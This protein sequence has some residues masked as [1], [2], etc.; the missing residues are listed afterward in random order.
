[1]EEII[2]I[3]AA[4]PDGSVFKAVV[5]ALRGYLL[6]DDNRRWVKKVSH[7]FWQG[8]QIG[9]E[10]YCQGKDAQGQTNGQRIRQMDDADLAQWLCSI[11]TADCCDTSCPG[12]KSCAIGNKGLLDWIKQKAEEK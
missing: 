2:V 7:E 12:R 5:D 8:G 6:P 10:L 11:M 3:R 9:V 1:M 4:D